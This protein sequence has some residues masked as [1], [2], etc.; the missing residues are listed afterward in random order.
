[1]LANQYHLKADIPWLET[2]MCGVAA[3][4]LK[5]ASRKPV[6]VMNI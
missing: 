6:V 3:A 4:G 2:A 1:M 5:H